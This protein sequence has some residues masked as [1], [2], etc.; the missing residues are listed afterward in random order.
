MDG[1]EGMPYGFGEVT[2]QAETPDDDRPAV[3]QLWLPDPGE[4]R[5]WSLYHVWRAEQQTRRHYG[6]RGGRG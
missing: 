6:L 3:A 5:G 1:N 2:N 4:R